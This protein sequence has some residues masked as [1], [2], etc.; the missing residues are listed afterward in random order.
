M[1]RLYE[2]KYMFEKST[3]ELIA[4]CSV[5]GDRMGVTTTMQSC[6]NEG[7]YKNMARARGSRTH[8]RGSSPRSLVLKTRTATGPHALSCVI[9][10]DTVLDF[11]V[12]CYYR[13]F[14][15]L[16]PHVHVRALPSARS[17]IP[18]P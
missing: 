2:S 10:H 16:H 18:A 5:D 3:V 12:C 9:V 17:A 14:T 6:A 8:Q 4:N 1:G 7:V 11:L 13:G 15:Y